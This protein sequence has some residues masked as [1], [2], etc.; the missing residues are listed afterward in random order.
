[1]KRGLIA[2][3]CVAGAF[4]CQSAVAADLYYPPSLKDEPI[5]PPV[6]TWRGLYIGGHVGLAT[7]QTEGGIPGL[8]PGPIANFFST[9]YDMNGAMWGG[10]VGYNFQFNKYVVGVEGTFDGTNLEGDTSCVIFLSCHREADWIGS[11]VGR[12]GFLVTPNTLIYGMGGIA[13]GKLNTDVKIGGLNILSGDDVHTGWT[14]GLGVEQAF[15]DRITARIEYAHVDLG[16]ETT[17][18]TSPGGGFTVPDR[19]SAEFDM[20]RLGVSVKLTD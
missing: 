19:T 5:P 8:P 3:L 10:H 18:L 11:V 15:S 7:G 17:T 9:D 4:A 2:V 14:A 20:L 13:W 12:A 16:D 1:M 6:T